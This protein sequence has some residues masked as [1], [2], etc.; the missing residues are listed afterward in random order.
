M[1]WR[2]VTV[3]SLSKL[4]YKMDYLVVRNADGVKRIHL[5]EISVLMI[6]STAVSL[7]AYLLCELNKRKI[8]VIF[9][10]ER[11]LPYG[12]LLPLHGSHNAS[13]KLREQIQWKEPIKAALW[14]E[15][16]REKIVGQIAVLESEDCAE[17]ASL[18]C[19]YL[20]EVQPGDA[21]N[22]EG[23]AAKVYFNALFGKAFSREQENA[24]N[25]ALDYG[26]SIVLS[27]VAREITACGY[28]TQLGVF[29]DNMFNKLNLACDLV[30][31]FRPLVDH[32]VRQM[33]PEKLEHDEKMKLVQILN[34]QIMI[35]GSRQYMLNAIR[36]FVKS[37]LDAM[38]EENVSSVRWPV[39]ELQIYANDDL[40]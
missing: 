23:H 2:V 16:V 30:E 36:I 10:D 9:C 7:T 28:S 3:S 8:D 1:S 13:L 19:S 15:I 40:L 32:A 20:E 11:R 22:R 12:M 6:E 34:R 27:A 24:W 38:R 14:A 37:A 18:L 31:P 33:A 17:A 25:A 4:D 21:T 35:D 5:S 29:H 39:Y 26:Y